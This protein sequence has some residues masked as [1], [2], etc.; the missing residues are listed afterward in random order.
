MRMLT[1]ITNFTSSLISFNFSINY[2]RS[3][4]WGFLRNGTFNGLLGM[5][6]RFELDIMLTP[7][8]FEVERI[9]VCDFLAV[10]YITEYKIFQIISN[11][12]S[13]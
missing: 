5:L 2:H 11:F 10:T 13:D 3:N 1:Q 4:L 8:R 12:G 6:Q 7:A 9:T